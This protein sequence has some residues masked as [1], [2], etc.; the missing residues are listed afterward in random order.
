MIPAVDEVNDQQ[1][2]TGPNVVE[3]KSCSH[4][5]KTVYITLDGCFRFDSY[6]N[7]RF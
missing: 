6:I 3:E 7:E 5:S 1:T 2:Q 4:L